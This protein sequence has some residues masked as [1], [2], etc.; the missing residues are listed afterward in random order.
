MSVKFR[1]GSIYHYDE[2]PVDI[3]DGILSADS[4]G[5]YLRANIVG[6]FGHTKDEGIDEE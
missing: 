3:H 5:Q 6:T 4:P 2:V 1:G